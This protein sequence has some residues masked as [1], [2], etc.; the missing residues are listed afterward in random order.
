[1]SSKFILIHLIHSARVKWRY[2]SVLPWKAFLS[3]ILIYVRHKFYAASK[4]VCNLQFREDINFSAI[5]NL[6]RI[7]DFCKP[8][9]RDLL[10]GPWTC[11]CGISFLMP[12][13]YY[14]RLNLRFWN[15][16]LKNPNSKSRKSKI[17]TLNRQC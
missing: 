16:V 17:F 12:H 6:C 4:L 11:C 3:Q 7:Q 8:F 9:A 13:M 2:L 10:K 5:V 1:M 15:M 14:L